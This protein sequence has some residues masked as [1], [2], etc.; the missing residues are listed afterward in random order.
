MATNLLDCPGLLPV[1]P[2]IHVAKREIAISQQLL[3]RF[4][5]SFQESK[6][7]PSASLYVIS[8]Y[9]KIQI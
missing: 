9:T 6:P 4:R 7:Y 8:V 1:T 2:T 3:G 5:S